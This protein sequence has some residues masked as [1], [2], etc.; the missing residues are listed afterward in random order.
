[1]ST[2]TDN[3]GIGTTMPV[4]GLAVMANVGIGTWSPVATL[5][6]DG[7]VATKPSTTADITALG[8]I[9]ALKMIMRVQGD[10]GAIEVSANPQI[11][12]G[13]D[14]QMLILQGDSDANTVKLNDG[15]GVALQNA[16]SFTLGQGD[17][18]TLI[19]DDGDGVWYEVGRTDN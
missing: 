15:N 11:A 1:L 8:G 2:A 7:T 18:M 14:G 3:V 16:V 6:V 13:V 17:T 10:G 5:E 4:G 9:Q 19:Y 12:S